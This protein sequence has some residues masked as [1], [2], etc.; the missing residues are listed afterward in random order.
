MNK[1][2]CLVIKTSSQQHNK[3]KEN[4]LLEAIDMRYLELCYEEFIPGF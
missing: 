3:I 2:I 4:N 1:I